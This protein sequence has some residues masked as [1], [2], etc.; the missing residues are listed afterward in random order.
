MAYRSQFLVQRMM[1]RISNL[2][3]GTGTGALRTFV[4]SGPRTIGTSQ[5]GPSNDAYKNNEDGTKPIPEHPR[6]DDSLATHV[7]SKIGEKAT[8]RPDSDGGRS[9]AT[10][11]SA[12]P[13]PVQRAAPEGLEKALPESVHPTETDG[14][15]SKST[16]SM[17]GSGKS[18]ATGDS[19]VPDLVQ[20]VAPEK[21]EKA[22]P[23]AVHPTKGSEID[24]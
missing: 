13:D 16:A 17:S 6:N 4:S 21:L 2:R 19:V 3:I 15:Q 20:K 12:V 14:G 22:L 11:P 7:E 10:G 18:H 8:S 1:P 9:H 23:E 24:P 5:S